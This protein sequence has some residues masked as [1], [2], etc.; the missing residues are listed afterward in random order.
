MKV[1]VRYQSRNGN[2]KAVAEVIAK[3]TG[4]VAK[5]ISEPVEEDVDILFVG[6]GIY[7][8]KADDH[9]LDFVRNLDGKKI[10]QLIAFSTAGAMSIASKQILECAK[11]RGI[12]VNEKTFCLIMGAKGHSFL[13]LQGGKLSEKQIGTVK[14]FV[15]ELFVRN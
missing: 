9:L 6:G 4:S 14:K 7:M 15:E 13:G 8:W 11:K 1:A 5:P 10:G 3:M 12:S 2:T